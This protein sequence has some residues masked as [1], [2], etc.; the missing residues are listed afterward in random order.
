[1]YFILVVILGNFT[2]LNVFLAIAVDNVGKAMETVEMEQFEADE[3]NRRRVLKQKQNKMETERRFSVKGY[4]A[5]FIL[6]FV[7][8]TGE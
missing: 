7:T 3:E 2:L 5:T 1:M 4:Y 6:S 8:A